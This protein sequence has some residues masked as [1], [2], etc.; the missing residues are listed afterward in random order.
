MQKCILGMF[1]YFSER[2][3]TKKQYEKMISAVIYLSV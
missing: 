2:N 1:M 3:E